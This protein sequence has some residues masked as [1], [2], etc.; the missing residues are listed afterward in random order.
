[1]RR[2]ARVDANHASIVKALRSC[3]WTVHDTSRLGDGFP[4][5]LACRGGRM[6]LIEIKDGAKAPSAQKPTKAGREFADAMLAAG[7]KVRYVTSVE[8][9]AS[10]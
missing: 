1:M 8:Q 2:R 4:D 5:V 9:V 7:V 10:L 6:E 3:G